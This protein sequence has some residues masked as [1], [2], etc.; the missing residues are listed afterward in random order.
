MNGNG[1]L[2]GS[3]LAK[4]DAV[5]NEDFKM[6]FVTH[7]TPMWVYDPSTLKFITVNDAAMRLYGY[8]REDYERMTVLDI[9]PERERDRMRAA[10]KARSDLGRAERWQHLNAR[11]EVMEVLTYGRNVR[12]N[13]IDAIL[14]IVTDR[15]EVNRAYR[16]ASDTR[17]LLD[18]IVSN[19][20]IGVFVKDMEDG[21]RYIFYNAACGEIVGFEPSDIIGK[22]DEQIFAP[23]QA[24]KFIHQD[25]ETI[26]STDVVTIEED[27]LR[28]DLTTRTIRTM[29]RAIPTMDGSRSRYLVGIS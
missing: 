19:L 20:P 15:T 24:K 10:V 12:F 7:P 27:V 23:E 2:A 1:D 17:S 28:S 18:S 26:Q 21:G 6:L 3:G 22:E 11:G 5:E 13:G 25:R 14:A 9:R 16:Q 4:L 29:K 8:S